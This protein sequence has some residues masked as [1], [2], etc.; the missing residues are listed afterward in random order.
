MVAGGCIV[1]IR[2]YES[3]L[4]SLLIHHRQHPILK[5]G[6][7]RVATLEQPLGYLVFCDDVDMST[8]A[9]QSI[10]VD[11]IQK[12]L[13]AGLKEVLGLKIGLPQALAGSK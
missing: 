8:P 2:G 5:P 3:S 11:G 7:G 1:P 6:I 12:R 10:A 9:G 4:V 13:R